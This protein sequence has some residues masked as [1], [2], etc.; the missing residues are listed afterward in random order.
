V[1]KIDMAVVAVL[2]EGFS[3]EILKLIDT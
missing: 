2:D 3:R 1:G